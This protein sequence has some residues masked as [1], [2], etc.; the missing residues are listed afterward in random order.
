MKSTTE[1]VFTLLKAA[2]RIERR[3]DRVLSA[4]KGVSFTEF[5]LLNELQQKH[6]GAATRVDL[7]NA[8]S[9]TPSAITRALKPLEKIGFV[10]TEKSEHDARRSIATLT[11]AGSE[12]LEDANKIVLDEIA[13][14]AIPESDTSEALNVLN[15]LKGWAVIAPTNNSAALGFF[16]V[17]RIDR[18]L[19]FRITG[20]YS[21]PALGNCIS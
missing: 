14:L 7:A 20:H 21:D 13:L 9:L 11:P 6:N 8:V 2:S 10:V 16:K 5:H 1:L 17:T 19:R 15:H 4:T 12:L 18:L 3:L